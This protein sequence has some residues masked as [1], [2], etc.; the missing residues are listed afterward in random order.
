[1]N[2]KGSM[3]PMET[4]QAMTAAQIATNARPVQMA[5]RC[6]EVGMNSRSSSVSLPMVLSASLWVSLIALRMATNSMAIFH[7][8]VGRGT[9]ISASRPTM[10]VSS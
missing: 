9:A 1:M 4:D 7:R 3:L 5:R 6:S 8:G 2:I 10:M